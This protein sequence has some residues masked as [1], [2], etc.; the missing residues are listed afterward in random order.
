MST[1]PP[2]EMARLLAKGRR[3]YGRC[4][5][6]N[7]P[8]CVLGFVAHE[9]QRAHHDLVADYLAWLQAQRAALETAAAPAQQ[10]AQTAALIAAIQQRL[11]NDNAQS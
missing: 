3:L 1:L 7:D 4:L 11:D 8:Q 2:E 9:L 6:K 10:A 5:A